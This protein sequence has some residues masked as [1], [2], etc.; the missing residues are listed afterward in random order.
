M[1]MA[2]YA[3]LGWTSFVYDI[4]QAYLIG[5]AEQDQ[6][7]PLRYPEG[8]IRDAHRDK[9]GKE[10]YMIL[11][12]NVYG[13]PTAARVFAKERDRLMLEE[14]PR[15]TGWTVTTLMYES[16]IYKIQTEGTS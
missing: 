16:C 2:L 15:R 6:R 7:Y 3:G 4:N 5:T 14:I 9:N 12:G 1:L 10:R 11:Q 13:V 8:P